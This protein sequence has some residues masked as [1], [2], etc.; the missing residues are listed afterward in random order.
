[1]FKTLNTLRHTT[2]RG[3]SDEYEDETG[4]EVPNIFDLLEDDEF[5]LTY[6]DVQ[7]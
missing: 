5:N 1:M 3:A 2:M 4:E 6:R 7:I